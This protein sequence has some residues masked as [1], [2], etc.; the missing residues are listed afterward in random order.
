MLAQVRPALE[1]SAPTTSHFANE[2]TKVLRREERC[3]IPPRAA[4]ELELLPQLWARG[5]VWLGVC[6]SVC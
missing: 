5:S 4:A 3:L 1:T 6:K 2:G